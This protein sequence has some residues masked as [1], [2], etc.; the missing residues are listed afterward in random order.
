[1]HSGLPRTRQ[2][3]PVIRLLVS[4]LDERPGPPASSGTE[5]LQIVQRAPVDLVLLD[6]MMPDQDGFTTCR[7]IKAAA[8][9]AFLPVLM[10]TALAEQEDR[11]RGL[12]A[13]AD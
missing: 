9:E 6:G 5:A 10:V 3:S 7:S 8:A 4:K 1:M 13:G 12:E 11:N 2:S